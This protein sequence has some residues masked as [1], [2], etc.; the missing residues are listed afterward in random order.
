MKRTGKFYYSNEKKTLRALGLTPVPGSGSGWIQKEDGENEIALVQLKSTDSRSY[1][2]NSLDMKKLEYHADVSN[3][4]PV[5]L[6]QFLQ[7]NKIYAIIDVGNIQEL[8]EAIKTGEVKKKLIVDSVDP[9]V[10][11][12]VKASSKSREKFF[13]E[14]SDEFGRKR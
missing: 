5:F 3:K 9:V 7:E 4:V 8:S 13:K 14:R 11:R 6:V 2:V 12:K 1:R 10:D